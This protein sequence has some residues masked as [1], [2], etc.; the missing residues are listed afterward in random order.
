MK[1][2]RSVLFMPGSNAR[3]LDKARTLPADALI[4][5]LED[6]VAPEAKAHARTQVLAAV[7]GGGYGAREV[8]V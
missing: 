1:P 3:A 7:R 4:L 6:A 2:R 5:D 8:I